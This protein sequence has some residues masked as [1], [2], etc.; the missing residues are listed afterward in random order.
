MR[1]SK[2]REE[3]IGR[4]WQKSNWKIH[5]QKEELS[6]KKNTMKM[7]M[8]H[9]TPSAS[10]N[11]QMNYSNHSHIFYTFIISWISRNSHLSTNNNGEKTSND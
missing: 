4:K 3:K 2:E 5:N 6:K 10:A 11:S 1:N 8:D 7:Q 9:T